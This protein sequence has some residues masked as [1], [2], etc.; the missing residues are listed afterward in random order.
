MYDGYQ[1]LTLTTKLKQKAL[2]N[3]G[4]E[5]TKRK[6]SGNYDNERT[7]FNV[8]YV[9]MTERNLYQEVKKTLEKRN[10]EYLNKSGTNLLN[11]I[12]FTSGPEFFERLGMKFV[13]S[14]RTYK[15]G[16]KKGQIVKVPDI[17][18]TDDIPNAVSY[19]FDCCMEYLKDFVGEENILLAQIHYDEDT[20]HLQAYFMPIV[21]EVKRKC[22]MKDENG[23]LIKEQG[24]TKD[25]KIKYVP[26][27]LRDE[28]GKIV[29]KKVKGNFLNNDQF[30]KDKGGQISFAKMQDSF[31]KFITN[32]GFKLD[33]GK[34]GAHIAHQ[35][36]L[37]YDIEEKKAELEELRLEKENTL[38][39]IKEAKITIKN[40]NNVVDKEILNPKKNL[41]GY[42]KDDVEK[43][44]DYSKN[45][46]QQNI[47]QQ[48]EINTLNKEIDK[49]QEENTIF[50]NNEELV[51]RDNLIIEQKEQIKEQKK[52]IGRLNELVEVLNNNIQ[53]LKYKLR[54]EIEIWKLRFE[55]M[56]NAINKLLHHEVDEYETYDD[57]EDLANKVI[58]YGYDYD[59][60]DKDYYD[61]EL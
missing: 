46:E 15:K 28:N 35:T 4:I 23:N 37:E 20:P 42:S 54:K 22:Y 19:Y 40:A 32:K 21:N 60:Y 39:I 24:Y 6:G 33:R 50:R 58:D 45:L 59:D 1:V 17:K 10:I 5:M 27:L 30:W 8:D 31:N 36:K 11:G 49:L 13:D 41:V 53:Y 55:K 52:E 29:Y 57:Y 3:I 9:S 7:K 38:S 34:I 16:K 18:S 43:M 25:G 2:Y 56:C 12:T 48:T 44:I 26:K 14:G 47:L 61:R 51:K